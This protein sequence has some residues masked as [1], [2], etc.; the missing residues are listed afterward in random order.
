MLVGDMERAR[1]VEELLADMERWRRNLDW[2]E[3]LLRGWRMG[4]WRESQEEKEKIREEERV[5]R[6]VSREE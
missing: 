2:M 3:E 1:K 5:N 6:R 4:E